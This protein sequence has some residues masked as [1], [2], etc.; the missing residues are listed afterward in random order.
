MNYEIR[1][2][3][4]TQYKQKYLISIA[5]PQKMKKKMNSER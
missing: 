1:M 4:I 5:V 3:G 2:A